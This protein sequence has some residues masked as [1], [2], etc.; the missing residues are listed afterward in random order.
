MRTIKPLFVV[1]SIGLLTLAVTACDADEAEASQEDE[2]ATQAHDDEEESRSDGEE[3][4]DSALEKVEVAED[5]TEFEPP[6]EKEQIPDGAWICD[7]DTVHYARMSEGDGSC[8]L[9]GMDLVHHEDHEHHGDHDHGD[10][11]H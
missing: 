11:D 9:C 7:M 1:L 8:P 4:Q 6:V 5:G 2:A 10:H 3:A